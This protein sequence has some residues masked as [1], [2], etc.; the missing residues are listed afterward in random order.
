MVQALWEFSDTDMAQ[1][2]TFVAAERLA[3][4]AFEAALLGGD[5]AA[6]TTAALGLKPYQAQAYLL[7]GD[8]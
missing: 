5:P 4:D 3:L 1:Y 2:A 7:F 6:I 8:L